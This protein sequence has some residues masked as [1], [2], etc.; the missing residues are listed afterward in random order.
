MLQ[1]QRNVAKTAEKNREIREMRE[2]SRVTVNSD[3][4]PAPAVP[5]EESAGIATFPSFA[6]LS[7]ISQ[8]PVSFLHKPQERS[9][10]EKN[11]ITINHPCF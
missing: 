2:R 11:P 7:L 1:S 6:I 10:R 3:R 8:F 9:E 4:P 5:F